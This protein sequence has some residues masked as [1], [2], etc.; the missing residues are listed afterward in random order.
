MLEFGFTENAAQA[1]KVGGEVWGARGVCVNI[2]EKYTR[3]MY[4]RSRYG[5]TMY[6][7]HFESIFTESQNNKFAT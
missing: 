6:T 2:K 5:F 3:G 4:S 1:R 7:E